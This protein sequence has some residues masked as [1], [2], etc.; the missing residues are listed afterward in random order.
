MRSTPRSRRLYT[1]WSEYISWRDP[2]IASFD[3]YL[4]TDPPGGTF[5]TGLE[6]A[7]GTP[8]ATYYAFRMPI[9]LPRT[10]GSQPLEVWGCV[11]PAHY[12]RLSSGLDQTAQIQFQSAGAR[13]FRTL[14]NVPITDAYGYFD[15][16]VS[17]PG[18]GTVRIA[19]TYPHG[20]TIFSRTV[21]IH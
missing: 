8:K 2:R 21:T 9:F 1:N 5:A 13:S 6:F 11:R 15:T 12:A 14:K 17:F 18:S 20:Q 3:Q 19:W 4:L 10:T 16:D 7:N